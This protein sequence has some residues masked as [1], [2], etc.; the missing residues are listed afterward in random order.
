MGCPLPVPFQESP[1]VDPPHSRPARAGPLPRARAGHAHGV[2]HDG[3]GRP[4]RRADPD[5]S[6]DP[7]RGHV[8]PAERAVRP[9][10]HRQRRD[11][12]ALR[13]SAGAGLLGD[14]SST[15]RHLSGDERQ[16]LRQPAEQRGLPAGGAPDPPG[17]RSAGQ[18][19][20]DQLPQHGLH[21]LR[22][23]PP[24]PV[25][26][27]ARRWL[28]GRRR[29]AERVCLP[30]AGPEAHG[31]RLRPGVHADRPGRHVLVRRGVRSVP[32]A[33]GRPGPPAAGAAAHA[34]R[35]L[36]EQPD[37]AARPEAEPAGQQG[38]RGY[39]HVARR[40]DALPHAGGADPGGQG[41]RPG[42]GPAHL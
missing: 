8:H 32:A 37:P 15:R 35:R 36:A 27:L 2:H 19:R 6:V 17:G 10:D 25:A 26:D 30:G 33:H 21:A 31:R 24:D 13:G 28:R 39:G 4:A 9:L 11:P 34:G 3:R 12:R 16:R 20:H 1:R 29:A 5:Q 22:P 38:L 42:R 40:Q 41:R 7:P 18:A 14:P 23:E